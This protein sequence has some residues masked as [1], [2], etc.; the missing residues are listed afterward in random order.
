VPLASAH[1]TTSLESESESESGSEPQALNP[2]PPPTDLTNVGATVAAAESTERMAEFTHEKL[3]R[4]RK[5]VGDA[6]ISS[7]RELLARI[8]AVLTRMIQSAGDDV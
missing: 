6:S 1:L 7:A 8:A 5:A 2:D 3:Y 4:L